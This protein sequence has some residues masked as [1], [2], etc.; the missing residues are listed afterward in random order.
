FLP[1]LRSPLFPYTTLFRSFFPLARVEARLG[2]ALGR[3]GFGA[4][5]G[6]RG[7]GKRTSEQKRTCHARESSGCSS[8]EHLGSSLRNSVPNFPVNPALTRWATRHGLYGTCARQM[9]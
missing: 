9:L 7:E 4:G 5:F 1:P 6:G 2:S 3:G 8:H